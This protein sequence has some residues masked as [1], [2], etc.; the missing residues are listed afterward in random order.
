MRAK[1]PSDHAFAEALDA[2][3]RMRETDSDSHHIAASLQY[4]HSRSRL[5]EELFKVTDRYLRFGMPEH[6]LTEMRRLIDHLREE[7]RY[8]DDGDGVEATLPI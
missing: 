1:R 2:A 4:L 5:L 3:E 7:A 8:A 6:E